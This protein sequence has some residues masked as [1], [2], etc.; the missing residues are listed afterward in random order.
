MQMIQSVHIIHIR[1][2]TLIHMDVISMLNSE[3]KS[4]SSKEES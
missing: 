4:G 1:K 3:I 2:V